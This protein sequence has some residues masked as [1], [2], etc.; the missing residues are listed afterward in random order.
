MKLATRFTI[1]TLFYIGVVLAAISGLLAAK[2]AFGEEPRRSYFDTATCE[3]YLRVPKNDRVHRNRELFR[4]ALS[5]PGYI[6]VQ[7]EC[8]QNPSML[9]RMESSIERMCH[10]RDNYLVRNAWFSALNAHKATCNWR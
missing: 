4:K 7:L 2:N 8:A 10:G 5:N 6:R 1:V 9:L 3:D